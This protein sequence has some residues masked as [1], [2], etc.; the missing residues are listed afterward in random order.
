M[1][2]TP[3][4]FCA[5]SATIAEVPYTPAAANAFRSACTPAPPPESEAAIVSAL[6][7]VTWTPFAGM[8]RIR[9]DG[10]DLSPERGTPVAE[11]YSPRSVAG[12][13]G[14]HRPHRTGVDALSRYLFKSPPSRS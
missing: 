12:R 5:V 14:P 3:A 2:V 6:G 13:D 4:V 8:T 10:C 9:F 7:T 1:A 11:A